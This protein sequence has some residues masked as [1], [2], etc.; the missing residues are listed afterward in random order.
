[1]RKYAFA[2]V[3]LIM[4]GTIHGQETI[5]GSGGGASGSGGSSSYSVGQITYTVN[6]GSNGTLS[7]GVQQSFEIF[8]LSNPELTA[9]VLNAV[10]YPNPTTDYIVLSIKEADLSELSYVLYDFNGRVIVNSKINDADTQIEMRSVSVGI[11]LLKVNKNN[12]A[13]KTFKII[14]H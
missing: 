12:Q 11:Y 14:K 4:V 13:L 5:L 1:M 10:T 6:S 3:L 2:I 9:I 7:Q 8:T